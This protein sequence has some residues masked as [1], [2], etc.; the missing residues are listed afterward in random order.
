MSR[1]IGPGPVRAAFAGQSLGQKLTGG[2]FAVG[3]ANQYHRVSKLRLAGAFEQGSDA[4]QPG[5]NPKTLQ[6]GEVIVEM[7]GN[8]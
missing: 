1:I 8:Q 7:H 5:L 2:A 6:V 3:A 4:F